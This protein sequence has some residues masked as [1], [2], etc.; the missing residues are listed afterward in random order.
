MFVFKLNIS[1]FFLN[2]KKFYLFKDKISFIF[3]FFNTIKLSIKYC[4]KH[5]SVYFFGIKSDKKKFQKIIA[6]FNIESKINISIV[7]SNGLGYRLFYL[8]ESKLIKFN[9][10]SSHYSYLSIPENVN[11]KLLSIPGDKNIK[12]SIFSTLSK[13]NVTQFASILV[14]QDRKKK[15]KSYCFLF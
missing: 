13:Q 9:F 8:E 5:N 12:L 3:P 10:G 14:K 11:V 15:T 1:Q 4:K 2:N 6:N 7:E